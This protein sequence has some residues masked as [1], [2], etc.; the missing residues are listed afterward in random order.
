MN[1]RAYNKIFQYIYSIFHRK[2]PLS[3]Q[4]FSILHP[5]PL[6]QLLAP[7]RQFP[8]RYIKVPFPRGICRI[9]TLFSFDAPPFFPGLEE[10]A[11]RRGGGGLEGSEQDHEE[12]FYTAYVPMSREITRELRAIVERAL[13]SPLNF[14]RIMDG[15]RV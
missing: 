14:H 2:D 6:L 8:C 3:I 1:R 15:A 11:A 4:S 5:S 10:Q 13:Y 9:A 12:R 7:T